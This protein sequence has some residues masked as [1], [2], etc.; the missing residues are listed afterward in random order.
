MIIANAHLFADLQNDALAE[1]ERA[2]SQDHLT[3]KQVQRAA[4]FFSQNDAAAAAAT[5]RLASP[6]N[7]VASFAVS[8]R[9]HGVLFFPDEKEKR[10]M[11]KF[12]ISSSPVRKSPLHSV[13]PWP[14]SPQS[15][16]VSGRLSKTKQQ[17]QRV[18]LPLSP[19]SINSPHNAIITHQKFVKKETPP[20]PR[21]P[22]TWAE[23]LRVVRVSPTY[24]NNSGQSSPILSP[25]SAPP[26]RRER[27]PNSD[28]SHK[29]L[30]IISRSENQ[31]VITS[32]IT[33]TATTTTTATYTNQTN[34]NKTPTRRSESARQ[35]RRHGVVNGNGISSPPEDASLL[36]QEKL[37]ARARARD[38]RLI[39]A[40][41]RR[42]EA[43]RARVEK[44]EQDIQGRE[45]RAVS[46]LQRQERKSEL[47][48][49]LRLLEKQERMEQNMRKYWKQRRSKVVRTV[50]KNMDV[51]SFKSPKKSRRPRPGSGVSVRSNESDRVEG[52]DSYVLYA[53]GGK[54]RNVRAVHNSG[55]DMVKRIA[56]EEAQRVSSIVHQAAQAEMRS[57]SLA[58]KKKMG[59]QKQADYRA[60][61]AR[62]KAGLYD[63]P[64][65][66]TA[67][68]NMKMARKFKKRETVA[69]FAQ[70]R[71]RSGLSSAGAS[72][73]NSLSPRSPR[74]Q[75]YSPRSTTAGAGSIRVPRRSALATNAG[76][77]NVSSRFMRQQPSVAPTNGYMN[78]NEI[79]GTIR[80]LP[81]VHPHYVPSGGGPVE[82]L[83]QQ[84]VG[85]THAWNYEATSRDPTPVE[86]GM[87]T[88]YDQNVQ[89]QQP[90][91]QAPPSEKRNDGVGGGG[92][93]E[94]YSYGAQMTNNIVQESYGVPCWFYVDPQ[95]I[96]QGP[97][98]DLQMRQWFEN[99]FF[100][101][102]LKMKR[103]VTSAF[104]PLGQIFPNLDHEAF[105]PGCGP[106]PHR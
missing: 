94:D 13:R 50:G 20:A 88:K 8:E 22:G 75:Q 19:R 62:S 90:C 55:L 81:P 2:E 71:A 70:R 41:Q 25:R 65:H 4:A 39:L 53:L 6:T 82:Q 93:Q 86:W 24:E 105:Q 102:D 38:R 98:D 32:N 9:H 12:P 80:P 47:E 87:P 34:H 52:E 74:Q 106:C 23:P 26:R 45:K 27:I 67:A 69:E 59:L 84:R 72:I 7:S 56:Q 49:E 42:E 15:P 35:A 79:E 99:G 95:G 91:E 5:E 57:A 16:L 85:G 37:F 83:P 104:L 31:H 33:D 28:A 51:E 21:S 48:R 17:K 10:S 46:S 68:S 101:P 103:G 76:A 60:K 92:M 54:R 89:Q 43:N 29:T 97:F 73:M 44:I 40:K 3:E 64:T 18:T 63:D 11:R 77:N 1:L 96:G 61:M 78:N 58:E 14:D 66:L 30:Q 100:T 36:A